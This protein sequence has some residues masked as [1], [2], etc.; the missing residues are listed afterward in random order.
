MTPD[1]DEEAHRF[2][3]A[4]HMAARN[5]SDEALML[6][7]SGDLFE[8]AQEMIWERRTATRH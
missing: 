3:Y 7:L 4:V 1:I 2:V 5:G 8:L 6:I